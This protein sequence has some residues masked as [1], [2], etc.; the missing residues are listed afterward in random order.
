MAHVPSGDLAKVRTLFNTYLGISELNSVLKL[1]SALSWTANGTSGVS[2]TN[3]APAGVGTAT[4]NRW[5]TLEDD[6]G[7][8]QYIPTFT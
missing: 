2:I 4:I 3:L 8:V 5:L 7:V 1:K 6:A